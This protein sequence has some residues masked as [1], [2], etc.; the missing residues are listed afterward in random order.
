MIDLWTTE[1]I[2]AGLIAHPT[3]SV[4]PNRALIDHM[5]TLLEDS[6]ARVDVYSDATGGKANLFATIG[7][8]RSGASCF[9]VIRTWSR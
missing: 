9:R 7:P 4:E 8:E 5:A 3:V 2:L 6:G 1:T